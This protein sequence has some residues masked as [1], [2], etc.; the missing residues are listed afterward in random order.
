METFGA[1]K[2]RKAEPDE[3]PKEKH[4]KKR[5]GGSDT[6]QFLKEHSEMKFQFKREELDAEKNEQS[7]LT[8]QQK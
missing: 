3:S 5:R 7:F 6:V 8:E 4:C 2:K 1:S